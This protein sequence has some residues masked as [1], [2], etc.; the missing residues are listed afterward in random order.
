MRELSVEN[1]SVS[2]GGNVI[3]S[4]ITFA[5]DKGDFLCITGPNGAGKST[6]LKALLGL[7]PMEKGAVSYFGSA[8][9]DQSVRNRIGYLPQRSIGINPIVPATSLEVVLLGIM[10]KK[11]FPKRAF[12]ADRECARSALRELG[13]GALEDRLYSTLSGGQQQ[14]VLLARCLVGTPDLLIMDEPATALDPESRE[15]FFGL[16]ER[17]NRTRGLT[18]LIVTHDMDY[19]GRF[20]SKLLVLDRSIQYFGNAEEYLHKHHLTHHHDYE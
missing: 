9:N 10:A 15:D 20:A 2:L 13:A 18:I 19:V 7:I 17:L 8:V 4:G 5:I 1:V 12:E 11:K 3:L 6:L 14:K 16:V